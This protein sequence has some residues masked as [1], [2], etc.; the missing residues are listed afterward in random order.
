MI[1][2]VAQHHEYLDGSG[3]PHGI[4]GNEVSDLV[5]R[6]VITNLD[7]TLKSPGWP[8]WWAMVAA[9]NTPGYTALKFA[10]S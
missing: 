6:S 9:A 3:Y 4:Q 8:T 1:K 7:L 10:T 5:R 2:A